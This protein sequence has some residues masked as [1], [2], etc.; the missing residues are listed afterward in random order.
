MIQ[1]PKCEMYTSLPYC[2]ICKALDNRQVAVGKVK[3]W[4]SRYNAKQRQPNNICDVCGNWTA[5][6]PC[7]YCKQQGLAELESAKF[8]IK[9]QRETIKYLMLNSALLYTAVVIMLY[10]VL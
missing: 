4:E 1:C 10:M 7:W 6:T 9:S 8:T 2:Q 3:E 5:V